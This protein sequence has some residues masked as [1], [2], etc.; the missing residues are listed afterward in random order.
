VEKSRKKREQ[1]KRAKPDDELAFEIRNK[2]LLGRIGLLR[3]KR[4]TVETP[5]LLPVVNP[6]SQIIA[7]GMLKNVFGFDALIT[8]SYLI[9]RRS[10]E[11][12]KISNVHE[13]LN[14]NGVIE[15][16]SGAYQ[17]LQYGDVEVQPNE[18]VR[19]QEELDSEIAVILDVPTGQEGSRE[20]AKHTVVETLRRADEALGVL[21]RKDILWVGP[22]QGGIYTD[23]VSYSAREMGKRDFAIHA[24]GSPTPVMQQYRFDVLVDM[25]MAA[26]RNLPPDRPLHLFG[27]GHPMIFS[28]AVALGCDIFDSASYALFARNGRYMTSQGTS[29]LEEL[30]YFPCNCPNCY[31]N[32]PE[33]IRKLLPVE[34]ERFLA[35]HNLH[36]CFNELQI[37]KQAIVD[38]RLWELVEARSH[39]HPALQRAFERLLHYANDLETETPVRKKKGQFITTAESLHRPEI[40]RHQERLLERYKPPPLAKTVLL[41]PESYLKPFRENLPVEMMLAKFERRKDLHICA[42]NLAYG[43]VPQELLDVYPLSQTVDALPPTAH[44]INQASSRIVNYLKIGRY[45]RCVIVVDEPWKRKIGASIRRL[46][47][48]KMRT[49]TIDVNGIDEES[50]LHV[51]NALRGLLRRR[52]SS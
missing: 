19:F 34:R 36:S 11:E 21:T 41:L 50:L 6:N 40:L 44:I 20:R 48:G 26:K 39:G 47:G 32:T 42:Y 1:A 2:D 33:D 37:V 25:V 10:R 43:I 52:R 4:G 29:K 38:G 31:K 51:T 45:K 9:W 23:L 24:L 15:T 12:G 5:F 13:L 46:G 8:N 16:D 22:V 7:P 3:T 30:E 14:F 27:A 17:I 28:L 35:S 18:I 49:R